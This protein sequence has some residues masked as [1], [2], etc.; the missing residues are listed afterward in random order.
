MS[1]Y[2]YNANNPLRVHLHA[3]APLTAPHL[4][5][6]SWLYLYAPRGALAPTLGTIAL[7]KYNITFKKTLQNSIDRFVICK[8]YRNNIY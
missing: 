5:A 1:V 7:S 4:S 2:P 3:S 8:A 6:P